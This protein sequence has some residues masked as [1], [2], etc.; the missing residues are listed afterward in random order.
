MEMPEN[1]IVLYTLED[2]SVTLEVRTDP[3]TVWL[4]QEQMSLL[5]D[6][7]R[8]VITKHIKNIFSEGELNKESNV[9]NM[10]LSGTARHNLKRVRKTSVPCFHVPAAVR[11]ITRKHCS[12]SGTRY[13]RIQ[14]SGKN[15]RTAVSGLISGKRRWS[16]PPAE[17]TSGIPSSKIFSK[18]RR[19]RKWN[20]SLRPALP[21]NMPPFSRNTN[22]N[23]RTREFQPGAI[24]QI[25][26]SSYDLHYG[27]FK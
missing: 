8:T 1:E 12:N 7:D 15:A 25:Q 13:F 18:S 4:T 3:K 16:S 9:Q 22:S 5:F 10:H 19:S 6:R 24:V 21:G 2:G 26:S 23:S 11:T 20:C 14:R 27:C 17:S